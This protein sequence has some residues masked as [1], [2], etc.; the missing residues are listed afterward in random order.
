MKINYHTH[1]SLCGHAKGSMKEYVER[2]IKNGIEILG[3]ADHAPHLYPYNNTITNVRM[4]ADKAFEYVQS[5][6]DLARE[7]KNDIKILLGFEMEYYPDFYKED[8]AFLDTFNPD[9][10]ILGQHYIGDELLGFHVH[11]Q[12]SDDFVLLAYVTQIL[13]AL[14]TGD[15]LYVAHPDIAGYNYSNQA[16]ERE[17]KRLCL[18]AKKFNVPLEINLL[19]LRDNRCY[20]NRKLFEIASE[21]GNNVVL[22]VDAHAPQDFDDRLAEQTAMKMIKELN[23][24]LVEKLI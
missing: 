18:G 20:P 2:A 14:N 3:F 10:Y 24:T 4:S 17:Y 22:G 21:V 15:F 9:Y 12:S 19:G 23:L 13:S 7:Y 11:K 6:K 8:K 1:T 5:I 16:I